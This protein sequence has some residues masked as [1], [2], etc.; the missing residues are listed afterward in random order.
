MT[1]ALSVGLQRAIFQRLANDGAL[2]A[3]VAGAVFDAVPISAPDLFVAIGPERVTAQSD[4]SASGTIHQLQ[5]S[6]VTER[7]GYADAKVVA[8]AISDALADADLSLPR[9]RVVSLRFQRAQAKRDEGAN[10]RRI[11]LWFRARLDGAPAPTTQDMG[12]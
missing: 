5:I 2:N 9:G 8:A 10:T 3:L 4:A 12:D 1:Y 6:V 7:N 11:D